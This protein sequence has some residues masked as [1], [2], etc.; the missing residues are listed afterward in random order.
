MESSKDD[1]GSGRKLGK[2]K[3][4]HWV[5]IISAVLM[6]I[7]T[8]ASA[9]SAYQASRWHG[10]ETSLYA[11]ANAARIH[12]SEAAELADQQ[13]TVDAGLFS[14]YCYA[15]YEGNLALSEFYENNLFRP[16][17]KAA[18]EA[19]KALKP[20]GNP[21]APK[22][23][24]EMEEYKNENRERSVKLE[25][26]AQ[27][28]TNDAGRA[29]EHSDRYVLMTVLFASVLFFAGISTKFDSFQVKAFLLGFGWM[30]FIVT[31]VFLVLQPVK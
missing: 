21:A 10:T 11:D 15:Y 27:G 3:H 16:E 23:P 9:W 22:S 4:H 2:P 13:I 12:A 18:V 29:I 17:M 26:S 24:F 25:L 1:A 6:A 14:D 8:V 5:E 7:A 30:L 20:L 28:K 31:V 19:W